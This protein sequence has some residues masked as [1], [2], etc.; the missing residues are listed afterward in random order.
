MTTAD[1]P[2]YEPFAAAFDRHAATSAYNAHY[3]RPAMLELLG[4]VRGARVL[5]AGCGPGFYA[6]QL[7]AAGAVVTGVDASPAMVALARARVGEAADL[8]VW[9][10]ETPLEWAQ[11]GSFDIALM[12]LVI[13]HVRDRALALSEMFR[14]LAPGGR[15]VVSTTHPTTDWRL[16]GGGYFDRAEVRDTWQ[17]DWDVTYWKQPLS[18]WCD[19]F[20]AA[21]F[22]IARLV[23]PRPAPSMAVSHPEVHEQLHR[24]PGF[25]AFSLIKRS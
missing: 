25:I 6:E 20:A 11:G 15:L 4:D 21:G 23:E 9:D 22:H 13:H 12:A 3:D 16:T 14:V 5:D 19:E 24:V 17:D 18:D 8:R 1:D 10:L 2:M 7:V